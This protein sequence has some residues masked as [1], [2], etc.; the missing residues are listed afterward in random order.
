MFSAI[1]FSCSALRK[2]VEETF[3]LKCV[4]ARRTCAPAVRRTI[5]SPKSRRTNRLTHSLVG[6]AHVCRVFPMYL[7]LYTW[8]GSALVFRALLLVLIVSVFCSSVT[9]V[10]CKG[11]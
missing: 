6:S 2:I 4:T 11:W 3:Y 5:S 10:C 1:S 7:D 8:V 9:G